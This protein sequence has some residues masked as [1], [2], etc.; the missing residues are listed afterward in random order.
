[1]KGIIIDMSE[2]I[3]SDFHFNHLNILHYERSQFKDCKAHND[4]IMSFWEKNVR[5]D[6]TIYFL[7][8]FG[9]LKDEELE[10]FKRL[11]GYKIMILGNHDKNI[12]TYKEIYHF[13]E[14][15]KYPLYLTS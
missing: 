2:W 6:D 7:G 11:P 12:K 9:S 4:A 3:T 14:V 10:R 8:D 13:D 5:A 15:V 1:M